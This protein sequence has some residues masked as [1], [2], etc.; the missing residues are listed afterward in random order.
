MVLRH[1]DDV[2]LDGNHFKST[3]GK[4]SYSL[5]SITKF[6]VTNVMFLNTHSDGVHI[7]G[8]ARWG[9]VRDVYGTTGDDFVAITAEDWHQYGDVCGIVS[10]I[11]V[12]N[13]FPNASAS[14]CFKVLGG[15]GGANVFRVRAKNL[16]GS[17][18]GGGGAVWVG[19][20]TTQ[21]ETIGGTISDIVIDTLETT[22]PNNNV[23][24][25]LNGTFTKRVS[26]L[27]SKFD[28]PLQTTN[29]II[30]I[31]PVG[32]GPYTFD[33]FTIENLSVPNFGP[34]SSSPALPIVYLAA[35]AIVTRLRFLDWDVPTTGAIKAIE[36]YGGVADFLFDGYMGNLYPG[37]NAYALVHLHDAGASVYVTRLTLCNMHILGNNGSQ[38]VRAITSGQLLPEVVMSN[39][40]ASSLAWLF[41]LGT[42]TDINMNG[43]THL[44]PSAG[45]GNVRGTANIT[46]QAA[47]NGT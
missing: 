37:N 19:D 10:D 28:N 32:A 25:N 38:L 26:L 39:I 24:F 16:F 14:A 6:K 22:V 9:V 8:P 15:P 46:R 11:V 44:S 33:E 31:Q 17:V 40:Q 45:I 1:V 42:T 21:G 5:A 18:L 29:Y 35:N 36:I 2:I 43:V 3:N 13:L 41:D 27:N 23:W 34:A 30:G 12:E 47:A 7:D 20:D 4:Y